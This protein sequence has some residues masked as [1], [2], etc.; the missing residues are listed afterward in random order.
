VVVEHVREP[1]GETHFLGHV[2]ADASRVARADELAERD[3]R[4]DVVGAAGTAMMIGDPDRGPLDSITAAIRE[5]VVADAAD[6]AA[7]QESIFV[8]AVNAGILGRSSSP[9][10]L[11]P[12]M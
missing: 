11:S 12:T 3:R 4:V 7:A 5:N 10:T 1:V 8:V 2:E 9:P 6:I